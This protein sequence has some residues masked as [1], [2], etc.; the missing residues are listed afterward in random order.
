MYAFRLCETYYS[1]LQLL[2]ILQLKNQKILE[3]TLCELF[4]LLELKISIAHNLISDKEI[5]FETNRIY[6]LQQKTIFNGTVNV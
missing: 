6:F 2:Y 3:N 4:V 5:V 1:I